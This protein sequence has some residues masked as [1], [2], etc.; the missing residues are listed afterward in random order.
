MDSTPEFKLGVESLSRQLL[1]EGVQSGLQNK[2]FVVIDDALDASLASDLQKE[3]SDLYKGGHMSPNE[4]QFSTADGPVRFVKPNIFEA[5]LHDANMLSKTPI[6]GNIFHGDDISS[7]LSHNFKTLGGTSNKTVKLQVNSGS[8]GCFPLHYD[9]PGPPNKRAATVLFYL[10]KGWQKEHGGE[11]VIQPFL[12]NPIK[13]APLFNRVVVFLSD[14]VLHRVL[15]CHSTRY[16][17]TLW[18]DGEDTNNP[19]DSNFKMKHLSTD[20]SN[21]SMLASSPLQRCLFRSAYNLQ[22][23]LSLLQCFQTDKKAFQ[24]MLAVHRAHVKSFCSN[25]KV[26]EFVEKLKEIIADKEDAIDYDDGLLAGS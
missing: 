25:E 6:I 9:N 2:G 7:C 5:D 12:E 1:S 4:V 11:V 8:G 24:Y 13:I 22:C 16:L 15:P 20:S 23:E 26:A 14:R 3:L 17:I 21:L 19:L 10:N 18:I